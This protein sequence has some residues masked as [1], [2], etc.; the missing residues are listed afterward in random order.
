MHSKIYEPIWVS[1]GHP[2][3]FEQTKPLL[4]T[5]NEITNISGSKNFVSLSE[6]GVEES[7]IVPTSDSQNP[8]LDN[9]VAEHWFAVY[10]RAQYECRHIFDPDARWTEGE[11]RALVR[12]LDWHVCLWAVCDLQ[13]VTI[14]FLA[15]LMF[16]LSALCSLDYR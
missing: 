13:S 10:E 2:A 3:G 4:V 5:E 12:K 15:V 1:Q 9:E 14:P 6:Y 8:F 16:V 11:E 7:L